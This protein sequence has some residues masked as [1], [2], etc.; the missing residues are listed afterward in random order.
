MD[1]KQPNTE[2]D[3]LFSIRKG[4]L[5]LQAPVP[6]KRQVKIFLLILVLLLI[7]IIAIFYPELKTSAGEF[8]FTIL[9]A[10]VGA[11]LAK[12]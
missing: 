9:Q 8:V 1:Q 12:D 7:L 5:K 3:F 2:P 4:R 6:D 10:V 11:W